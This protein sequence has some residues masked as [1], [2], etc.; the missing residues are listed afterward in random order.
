MANTN[1]VFKYGTRE[2]Y[3]ALQVKQEN[4]LYFLTDT[5]EM[6]RGTVALARGSHY[7]GI[8]GAGEDD[9]AV[10]ARVLAGHKVCKDDTF[11]VKTEIATD[12]FSHTA[13]VYD[14][15]VWKAM[16]GNYDAKNVYFDSD[17]VVTEAIGTIQE[18]VNGQATL[19]AQG[20]SLKE[21][22][23][24][25]FAE[26]KD[27]TVVAPSASIPTTAISKEAGS[28]IT[29]TA[30]AVLDPGSYSFGPATGIVAT[31]AVSNLGGVEE[32]HDAGNSITRSIARFTVPDGNV[33]M[34]ATFTYPE[35]AVPNNNLGNA[36]E[37]KK[38][39][40]ST[41]TKSKVV[42]TGYRNFFYGADA[43]DGAIDSAVIRALTPSNKA[44]AKTETVK[45]TV[46]A[47]MKRIIVAV[48]KNSGRAG[49]NKVLLETSMNADVT[50]E[51]VKQAAGVQ[52]NGA[53]GYAAI[54]YDVWVYQPATLTAGQ[55]HAITL[56]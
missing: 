17:F 5:G 38:I 3:D 54:E 24:A 39:A 44:Y 55:V 25:L 7:E 42:A 23:S 43:G 53:N 40:A 41:A 37:G 47:G 46:G 13:Y 11:V 36:V 49:V 52:V 1:V 32:N 16:D 18:L 22:L 6:F 50:N 9:N 29:L 19:A 30:S 12:K 35:G 51:Y 4:A 56:A 26:A 8:K 27:P 28:E 15:T 34:S 21:V 33:S 48:P 45:C 2:Q 10:I 31:S 20:K 14:G